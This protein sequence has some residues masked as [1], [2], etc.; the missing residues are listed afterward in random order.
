MRGHPKGLAVL[1]LTEMWERFSYYG[2]RGLLK[3]YM[4]NYLFVASRQVLQASPGNPSP[5]VQGNPEDVWWWPTIRGWLNPS[6]PASSQAS[7]LYSWY[8]WLVYLTPILGGYLADKYWGQRRTVI[9]GGVIMAVG[10]FMMVSD[11]LFFPALLLLVIGNGAFKPNISTQVGALYEE[12]DPRRDRAFSI[13][14]VGINIGAFICNLVCG[15]LAAVKGWSWGFGAAGVG[16][17][18]GLAIYIAGQKHLAPDEKMKRAAEAARI[19]TADEVAASEGKEPYR[20]LEPLAPDTKQKQNLAIGAIVL[21]ALLN[22]PFWGAYEQ[23]GNTMQTWADENIVWPTVFGFQIPSTWYQSFNPFMIFF[24]TPALTTFWGLQAKK[25]K[26]PSSVVKMAIGSALLGLSFMMLA[27]HA[28][29]IGNGKASLIWLT[30]STLAITLGELYLSPIGLS[31]VS[32]VSPKHLISAMMGFWF[33]SSS[34]GGLLSGWLGVFYDKM[35]HANF[36]WLMAAIGI[37]TAFATWIVD[38]P[39]KKAVGDV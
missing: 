11:N 2:M 26:E 19:K 27:V 34:F 4:V 16:L 33:F 7:L 14:Y 25:G 32:K 18:L 20:N 12:G 28:H 13:F 1:F 6:L 37:A 3:L 35:S 39:L 30:V 29:Q 15:T 17:L 31:F 36:F 24:L 5:I 9:F 10:Q 38:K 23:G 22:I 21:L 8:I